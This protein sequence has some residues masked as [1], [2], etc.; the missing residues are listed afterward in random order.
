VVVGA[1]VALAVV[2]LVRDDGG[3]GRPSGELA[4]GTNLGDAPVS[5]VD[6]TG[7]DERPVVV[8]VDATDDAE[9]QVVGLAAADGTE[10]WRYDAEGDTGGL[11]LGR[12]G[13]LVVVATDED[14]VVGLDDGSGTPRW[15]ADARGDALSVVASG[16]VVV[17][18]DDRVRALATEDGSEVWSAPL[19]A[20]GASVLSN[21]DDVVLVA[22]GEGTVTAFA[23]SDGD[24][25][26]SYDSGGRSVEAQ[27]VEGDVFVAAGEEGD[28]RGRIA[29]LALDSG[30]PVWEEQVGGNAFFGG[31]DGG[32]AVFFWDEAD[33]GSVMAAGFDVAT[34]DRRWRGPIG[35]DQSATVIAVESGRAIVTDPGQVTAY[36]V[37]TGDRV[38]RKSAEGGD[39]VPLAGVRDGVVYV[40]GAERS[41]DGYEVASGTQT[42]HFSGNARINDLD[43][44]GGRAFAASD[45]GAVYGLS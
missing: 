19:E 35:D 43:V 15:S 13:D 21:D 40:V 22:D 20:D 44:R 38:W 33:D 28:D 30:E 37:A 39:E 23:L 18:E 6:S 32:V 14:V 16:R 10:R 17:T 8:T 7:G 3:G 26:W 12:E 45:D 24:R 4:W 27:I 42:L 9:P 11:V 41:V 1:L 29:R 5:F 34:G 31:A 2:L 25:L 36:D